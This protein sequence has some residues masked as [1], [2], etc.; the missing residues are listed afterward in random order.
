MHELFY[1]HNV[2]TV[3]VLSRNTRLSLFSSSVLVST[4]EAQAA[5]IVLQQNQVLVL[6]GSCTCGT[7]RKLV[8]YGTFRS[9]VQ[10]SSAKRG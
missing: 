3:I 9:S 2:L 6:N 4:G 7:S 1:K 5:K 10:L 8:P